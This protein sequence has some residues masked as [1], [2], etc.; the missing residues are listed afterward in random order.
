MVKCCPLRAK[1]Y[2]PAKNHFKFDD[3]DDFEHYKQ[4][5]IVK[6]TAG[7]T[8]KCLR[9]FNKWKNNDTLPDNFSD[10]DPNE[11]LDF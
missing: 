11:L 1:D 7:D 8:K 10:V 2:L 6:N 9:L 4:G 3:D 5:C